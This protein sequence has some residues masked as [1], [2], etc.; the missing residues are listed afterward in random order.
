MIFKSKI[1]NWLVD[2]KFSSENVFV[3]KRKYIRQVLMEAIGF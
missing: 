2:R 3:S 1:F